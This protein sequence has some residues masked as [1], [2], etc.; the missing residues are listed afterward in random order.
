MAK[1]IFVVRITKEVC[2]I[3]IL[4]QQKN[5]NYFKKI[6]HQLLNNQSIKLSSSSETDNIIQEREVVF[7]KNLTVGLP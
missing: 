6:H 7:K 5:K 2:N 1:E 4:L 3:K